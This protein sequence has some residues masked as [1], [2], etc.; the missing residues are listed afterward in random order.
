MREL[1]TPTSLAY[2][3]VLIERPCF[4]CNTAD[5]HMDG[6]CNAGPCMVCSVHKHVDGWATHPAAPDG[7]WHGSYDEPLHDWQPHSYLPAD[8]DENLPC[9][10]QIV[11]AARSV[12]MPEAYTTDLYRDYQFIRDVSEHPDSTDLRFVWAVRRWGTHI[13]WQHG[14]LGTL[15]YLKHNEPTAKLFYWNGFGLAPCD[16]DTAHVLLSI[17]SKYEVDRY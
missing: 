15:A 9:F 11:D 12:A 5:I 10:E 13:L 4:F 14:W 6:L 7:K 2:R 8:I 16:F 17:R 1:V 3:G